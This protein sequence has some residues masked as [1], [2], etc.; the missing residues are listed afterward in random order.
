MPQGAVLHPKEFDK[1]VGMQRLG[2]RRRQQGAGQ[3]DT[4]PGRQNVTVRKGALRH[5]ITLT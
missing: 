3:V 1:I 5:E 4:G 2:T